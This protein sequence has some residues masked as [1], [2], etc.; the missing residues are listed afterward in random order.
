[1]KIILQ[2]AI[3][4]SDGCELF[5][6]EENRGKFITV[7]KIDKFIIKN[8]KTRYTLTNDAIDKSSQQNGENHDHQAKKI[9][10]RLSFPI[11]STLA[12]IK[13]KLK[14]TGSL[15]DLSI[16]SKKDSIKI[17]NPNYDHHKQDDNSDDSTDSVAA[18]RLRR[19]HDSLDETSSKHSSPS[20]S[21]ADSVTDEPIYAV[22]ADINIDVESDSEVKE[23]RKAEMTEKQKKAHKRMSF[24]ISLSSLV[25]NFPAMPKMRSRSKSLESVNQL[26]VENPY[27]ATSS[28]IGLEAA[29]VF[30]PPSP[31]MTQLDCPKPPLSPRLSGIV[32]SDEDEPV[33]CFN[34]GCDVQVTKDKLEKHQAVC[35]FALQKCPN[36]GCELSMR[37]AEINKHDFMECEYALVK[38]KTMGCNA[39]L[40]RKMMNQHISVYHSSGSE[41]STSPEQDTYEMMGSGESTINPCDDDVIY[42]SSHSLKCPAPRCCFQG[43]ESNLCDHICSQHSDLILR[44]LTELR[45][46]FMN[47]EAEKD[48]SYLYTKPIKKVAPTPRPRK[49]SSDDKTPVYSTPS[50]DNNNSKKVISKNISINSYNSVKANT[51]DYSEQE[52]PVYSTPDQQSTRNTDVHHQHDNE[53]LAP[54]DSNTA[55]TEHVYLTPVD[56]KTKART[57]SFKVQ[58]PGQYEYVAFQVKT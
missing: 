6:T 42:A 15:Q 7:D 39:R 50:T 1:M 58:N 44:H 20:L 5:E 25:P 21:P 26:D 31:K 27:Y 33:L 23:V 36:D 53:Y 10:K 51:V 48:L 29:P 47:K 55:I 2:E 35:K 41:K 14:T 4:D 49:P 8:E 54:V 46:I 43:D 24:P 12:R 3:G 22:S 32:E 37:R 30:D 9:N 52:L 28:D 38:C 16:G 17:A 45:S 11:M 57:N 19:R 18:E 34:H 40:C 13:P 56:D